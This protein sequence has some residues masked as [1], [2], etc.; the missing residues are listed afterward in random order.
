MILSDQ[1]YP[2]CEAGTYLK[3]ARLLRILVAVVSPS[4]P[5]QLREEGNEARR[6]I[7][8]AGGPGVFCRAEG[9]AGYKKDGIYS[10]STS[11]CQRYIYIYIYLWR[12]IASHL[13]K[14]QSPPLAHWSNTLLCY[15]LWPFEHS[16]LRSPSSYKLSV[17][18]LQQQSS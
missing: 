14:S 15:T 2:C 10:N 16:S 4:S 13:H 11:K 8:I 18:P 1:I 17:E 9:R 12:P 6:T 5:P 3:K 7:A